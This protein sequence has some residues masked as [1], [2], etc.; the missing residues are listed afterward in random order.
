VQ[1]DGQQLEEEAQPDVDQQ[2]QQER[3]NLREELDFDI[4]A[5]VKELKDRYLQ[6]REEELRTMNAKSRNLGTVFAKQR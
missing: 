4:D 3:Q 2:L 5:K 6:F 1:R